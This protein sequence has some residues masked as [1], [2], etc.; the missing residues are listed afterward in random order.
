MLEKIKTFFKKFWQLV[1]VP[2]GAFFLIL[3]FRKDTSK[4]V[5]EEI[6]ETKKE[7]KDQKEEIENAEEV[8]K[9]EEEKLTQTI[10]DTKELLSQDLKDKEER[11]KVASQFF[12]E[13]I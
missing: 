9:E 4:E 5:K 8:K 3:F 7:I 11:D 13:D 12:E 1:F 6:K 10:S 2:V